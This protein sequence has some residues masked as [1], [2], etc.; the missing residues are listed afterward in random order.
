[1]EKRR[2]HKQREGKSEIG[3]VVVWLCACLEVKRNKG[4]R[5][6]TENGSRPMVVSI[7][8]AK[9][10]RRIL[11][12]ALCCASNCV[13][14]ASPWISQPAILDKKQAFCPETLLHGPSF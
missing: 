3:G 6:T 13:G 7:D 1:M 8:D 10:T 2:N 11:G 9:D 4:E 5:E 14:W 12:L